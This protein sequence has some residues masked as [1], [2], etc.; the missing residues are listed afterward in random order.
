[1]LNRKEAGELTSLAF[2]LGE[3]FFNVENVNLIGNGTGLAIEV[4]P[5]CETAEALELLHREYPDVLFINMDFREE[6]GL[7]VTRYIASNLTRIKVVW[8]SKRK[9][10]ALNAYHESVWYFFELPLNDEKLALF[11]R[12]LLCT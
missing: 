5:V 9:Q 6:F 4:I 7:E 2:G 12:R 1:L 3:D 11:R 8:L 10:Q